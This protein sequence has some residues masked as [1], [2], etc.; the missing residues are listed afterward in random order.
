[1]ISSRSILTEADVR[2]LVR[3]TDA[4]E[5]ADAAWKICRRIDDEPLPPEER[6]A[7]QDILRLMAADAAETVRRALAVTLKASPLLRSV[8]RRPT[9]ATTTASAP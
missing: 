9:T 7:A 1:M 8:S 3:G 5:R 6:K 4:A 2:A